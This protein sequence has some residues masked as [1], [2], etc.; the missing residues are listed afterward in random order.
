MSGKN[1]SVKGNP[2]ITLTFGDQAENHAGMQKIGELADSGFTIENLK[3]IQSRFQSKGLETELIYLNEEGLKG[4][5]LLKEVEP[6]AI[7]IVEHA[8]NV[9]IPLVSHPEKSLF[10]EQMSL[11]WDTQAKMRGRVVNKRARYNLC[12]GDFS[13]EADFD[14]GKGTVVHFDEIPLTAELRKN[15]N[16]YLGI[17]AKNLQGEGNF[18]YDSKTTGIGFHGDSERRKVAAIRLGEPI[19]LV[20]SWFH[21]SKP[22]GKPIKLIL[23][24][25]DLYVM[26]EKAV[27]F[28]WKKRKIPTLR[29]AAGC[30]KYTTLPEKK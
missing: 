1:K 29:H 15:L 23:E 26:S 4:T 19:P 8:L 28:D 10:D 9:L 20:Y 25:G 22:I 21:W 3:K 24:P 13:Q 5:D 30:A 18:Y 14:E 17:K 16:K 11:T 27:G 6:A 2:A 7:L 12:Y